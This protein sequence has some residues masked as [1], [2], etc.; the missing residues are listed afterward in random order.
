MKKLVFLILTAEITTS[1]FLGNA[2][3]NY[4]T[5][6]LDPRFRLCR[7]FVLHLPEEIKYVIEQ[8]SV[9]GRYSYYFSAEEKKEILIWGDFAATSRSFPRSINFSLQEYLVE[10]YSLPLAEQISSPE[11]KEFLK[12]KKAFLLGLE[13]LILVLE[14]DAKKLPQT[15]NALS[16]FISFEDEKN[17]WVD[18]KGN[19]LV[20]VL[21]GSEKGKWAFL[22][23]FDEDQWYGEQY[24][25]VCF[26]PVKQ[27]K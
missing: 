27:G 14:L 5:I 10:I 2:Q 21:F 16:N 22:L 6:Q 3:S 1:C 13:G 25:L 17:A 15:K 18:Y 11:L 24:Y 12:K 26:L 8:D 9:R 4:D 7:S 20:P 23:S 19:V